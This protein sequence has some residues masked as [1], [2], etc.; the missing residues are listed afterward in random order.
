MKIVFNS[1]D[2]VPEHL[3]SSVK[4]AGDGTFVH[5][6]DTGILKKNKELLDSNNALKKLADL[7]KGLDPEKLT[8]EKIK[9][10]IADQENAAT[11]EA[12][13]QQRI[14]QAVAEA[15]RATQGKI[16][17]ANANTDKMRGFLEKYLVDAQVSQAITEAGGNARFILPTIRNRFK[18]V[19]KDGDFQV[20]VLAENGKDVAL[21]ATSGKPL[22]IKSLIDT[23][24]ADKDYSS[25]FK[26]PVSSGSGAQPVAGSGAEPGAITPTALAVNAQG[27]VVIPRSM[28]KDGSVYREALGM[29]KGDA[30]KVSFEPSEAAVVA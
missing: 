17:G 9:A 12:E 27:V 21:D 1:M 25:V 24:K 14:E 2:E 15:A 11:R 18:V 3:K 8:P 23:V 30:N 4:D 29:V 20:Q 28:A 16:D 6:G 13:V 7:V 22:S 26:T 5:D 10:A 19:E